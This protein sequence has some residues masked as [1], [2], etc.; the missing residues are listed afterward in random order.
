MDPIPY[1]LYDFA[2]LMEEERKTGCVRALIAYE[3]GLGKTILVGMLLKEMLERGGD[4]LSGA[5]P[6]RRVLI[7]T[8][9][10]VLPQFRSEMRDKFG[11]EFKVVESPHEPPPDLAIASMDTIKLPSWRDWVSSQTWDAVVVDEYHRASPFNMRGDLVTALTGKTKNFLALTA[12]P[13]DGSSE[14]YNFRLSAIAPAPLVIRRTKREALDAGNRPIFD[15]EVLESVEEPAPTEGELDFYESA[16]EYVRNRYRAR[17]GG[18]LATLVGRAISSS[19]RTGVSMLR[20]RLNKILR[21]ELEEIEDEDAEDLEERVRE[22]GE[23]TQEEIERILGASASP[24]ELEAELNE[25]KPLI[26][27]GESL[28]L[29]NPVDSKGKRLYELVKELAS[30][31]D[32]CGSVQERPGAESRSGSAPDVISGAGYVASK[33]EYSTSKSEGSACKS[34][35]ESESE[36]KSEYKSE[37]KSESGTGASGSK[38][39]VPESGVGAGKKARKI[40][41]FTSFRETV[42]Y[43]KELLKEFRPLEITGSTDMEDR[44]KIVDEFSSKPEHRVLIGT[45]AM[46]ESLNLQAASVEINYEV[47][48]SPVAYIQRVG[49][50]WRLKQEHK[51]LQIRNF[52]PPFPVEKRVMEVMLEKIRRINGE[53][54]EIGLS[55]FGRELGPAEKIL[56]EAYSEASK[57][58]ERVESAFRNAVTASREIVEILNKSMSLPRVVNVEHLQK[59][60]MV[61]ISE[62]VTEEDLK[63]FLRHLKDAG[64]G[65]GAFPERYFV[66]LGNEFVRVESL[67]LESRGM[68]AAIE[69]GKRIYESE[70]VDVGRGRGRGEDEGEGKCEGEPL[71]SAVHEAEAKVICVPPPAPKARVRFNY[72]K[73]MEGWLGMAE[74]K[75]GGRTLY[76]EPVLATEDG[77]LT[78]RGILSLAPDFSGREE[79][80][81]FE[82]LGDY[83]ARVAGKCLER[84]RALW[85]DGM[86]RLMREYDMEKDD[87]RKSWISNKIAEWKA[88]EPKMEAVSFEIAPLVPVAFSGVADEVPTS[89]KA[90][91]SEAPTNEK[92]SV[93]FVKSSPEEAWRERREVELMAMRAAI[94][95]Y[96]RKGYS[97]TDVSQ[98]NR[99][100]DLLCSSPSMGRLSVE[101]KGLRGGDFPVLTQNE[102]IMAAHL[103]GAYALFVVK[104]EGGVKRIYEVPDPNR[105]LELRA[106]MRPHYEAH[107]Y[108]RFEVRA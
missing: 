82:P 24:D 21:D 63:N 42:E 91:G 88:R 76:A 3:T 28:I 2:K 56:R 19:I 29:T 92:V 41:I 47:P 108:E 90:A 104:E 8:P 101:V 70:D 32:A 36:Y 93:E 65:F 67:S 17:G 31:S 50:I 102:R 68:R 77:I 5:S 103:G 6:A 30:E 78:Y 34:E 86:K 13:H 69:A 73:D 71:T 25:L 81:S 106:V 39:G 95:Y 44:K 52:L 7:V 105:N 84:A 64:A 18:L 49:R 74:V 72:F 75:L 107:G 35:F 60:G 62:V 26:K 20:R 79:H 38:V 43:L 15:H 48:W 58:G 54:G 22:G 87:F 9:P 97:V 46:G 98:E 45:D 16:E 61:E 14:K 94:D 11:L 85:E 53:F 80:P 83:R 59:D 100:Y 10:S 66:R 40:I 55:V 37:C 4:P 12:T 96:A 89:G 33:S 99:G 51:V 57:A 27:K 23:L 1:Q